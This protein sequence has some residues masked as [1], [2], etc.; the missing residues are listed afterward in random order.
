[1][2]VS[3][4]EIGG[5]MVR[6]LAAMLMLAT[7]PLAATAQDES[8]AATLAPLS[9]SEILLLDQLQEKI[10]SNRG[11]ILLLTERQ[12]TAEG[13]FRQIIYARL[14]RVTAAFFQDVLSIAEL[15]VKHERQGKDAT[16]YR[17]LVE[18]EL[19]GLPD[20]AFE[21]LDRVS[22]R[23]DYQTENL[24]TV[25]LVAADQRLFGAIDVVDNVFELLLDY[26]A[27]AELLQIDAADVRQKVGAHIV[28]SASSRSIFLALAIQTAT[29][30]RASIAILPDDTE[31]AGEL[32]A[33]DAR[34][35]L[36]AA[37]LQKTIGFLQTLEM[38]S[39][40]YRQ[41]VLL[42]TGEITTDVL[43]VGVVA[44][45]VKGWSQSLFDTLIDQGPKLLLKMFLIV[46]VVYAALRLSRLVELGINRGLDTS[47]VQ[48]SHLLRRMLVATGKNLVVVVG[49]LIA[50]SQIGISLG[51]LLAGLGI[52]G[53]II[54]FAMQ[55]ALSNFASGL[56]ILF[57]R[58]F[59][60]GDTVE[61]GGVGGKV[62]SMS[63][64]NT[65][66]MTFDNQALVVPN[67][68]IW[69]TVITNV[70]A[71]RTRRVDLVFGI[72]YGDDIDK[73]ESIFREIVKAHE[74]VLDSPEPAIRVHELGDW[75]V[76]FIVRPWVKT[77]DY[78]GVYWDLTRAV[79]VGL[80]EAG[81]SIPFPQRDVHIYESEP[82]PAGKA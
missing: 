26:L 4:F 78:W 39:R 79:K 12:K 28:D 45:L 65:T 16:K 13:I 14:D 35:K 2:L 36:T 9:E 6:I 49:V 69:S 10:A 40:Q 57:Y 19:E 44:G 30:L 21:A 66:I 77:E 31:I 59:D 8:A 81:I 1:M 37:A 61:A 50:L 68:L 56:L 52:A 17:R 33:A 82:A 70:T 46:A 51:P 43:D 63:L 27:V 55:D 64:V 54:G 71:Q 5:R 74:K 58:P 75:S 48:I 34:V 38:E 47:H 32:R 18:K 20:T 42:A 76:K 7:A 15:A 67:N 72:S 60:V 53:F 41:Q 73:A 23:I 11:E 22:S 3:I 24:S 62:K 80:D 29:T 25:E